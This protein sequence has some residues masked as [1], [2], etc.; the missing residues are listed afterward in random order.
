MASKDRFSP[1][2]QR[3]ID[4]P[5]TM[6]VALQ[7]DPSAFERDA[8]DLEGG[9]HQASAAIPNREFFGFAV[10]AG[11]GSIVAMEQP[12]WLPGIQ[13]FEDLQ[14]HIDPRSTDGRFLH[15]V[16]DGMPTFGIWAPFEETSG[17][18][19]P[20]TVRATAEQY[21]GARVA[22]FISNRRQPIEVAVS[23][24]GLTLLQQRVLASVVRTG[25][26]RR[27]ADEVGIAYGTA[28]EAMVAAAER[29]NLPNSAALV[30]TVVA[31]GFGI[32][33]GDIDMTM[34][35]ADMLCISERQSRVALLIGN[36]S[37][38]EEAA[39]ALGV[40][41]AVIKK[42]M[43]LLF[44]TFGLQ[45]AIELARLVTEAQALR[46]FARAIDNPPGFLDPAIEPSRFLI[47]PNSRGTIAWSDYGPA[48]GK[49][50]LIVHSSWCC[51]AVPRT[52]IAALHD[53]GW[54]PIA[55][56]RPGFGATSLGKATAEDP[57][58]QGVE[59]AVQILD[60]LQID[61]IAII[62]RCGAQFTHAFKAAAPGRVGPVLLVSP[63]P[64]ASASGKRFGVVGAFKEAFYRSPRLIEMFFRVISSQFNLGRV[65]H[66]MRSISKGAP[67][68][69]QLCDDP[70]FIRDRFRALRPFATGNYIG[71]VFEELIVSHGG[72]DFAPIPAHDW[73]VLQGEDDPLNTMREV[74][75]YFS[76]LLVSAAFEI[77]PGG[78]RF[79][80]SSHADLV[81]DRLVRL[82]SAGGG[83][84]SR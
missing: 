55:I 61:R 71:G 18:N 65:D 2:F 41:V 3:M 17:W 43:Q 80:T 20:A 36:G 26:I 78:G 81:V 57:F 76:G 13:R 34:Q 77:V 1:V 63:S 84:A 54:R 58:T 29:M 24:F 32:L 66:L 30:R 38:R 27:A 82:T 73:I 6:L 50:V 37:S 42:E 53:R 14:A 23:S 7:S 40:S 83:S 9:I 19:L 8:L 72:W 22:L 16:R 69:D 64:Q 47:R 4:E 28:R 21:S 48:S 25:T 56:D 35:L 74:S 12:E 10:F 79:L 60:I 67:I 51:R 31:A 52:L 11:D 33:P 70:Q 49:P 62:A 59:D 15:L 5:D 46:S 75:D 45:S 39:R 68:D 44:A